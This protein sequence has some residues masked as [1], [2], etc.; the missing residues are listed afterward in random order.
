VPIYKEVIEK[1]LNGVLWGV[2]IGLGV[3]AAWFTWA[4]WHAQAPLPRPAPAK[5][6]GPVGVPLPGDGGVAHASVTV[7]LNGPGEP[8][9]AGN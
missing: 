9:V 3:A 5:P 6:P 1:F 2:V 4:A 8:H 7:R